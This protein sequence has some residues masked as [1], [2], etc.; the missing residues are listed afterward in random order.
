V[1]GAIDGSLF[2]HE[3]ARDGA[4]YLAHRLSAKVLLR[5]GQRRL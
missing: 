1:R 2:L 3:A 4:L 5:D